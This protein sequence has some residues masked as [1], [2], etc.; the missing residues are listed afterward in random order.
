MLQV[1]LKESMPNE[2][3]KEE[4]ENKKEVGQHGI[5]PS[6]RHPSP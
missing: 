5:R 6:I 2:K 3:K 1:F 4:K